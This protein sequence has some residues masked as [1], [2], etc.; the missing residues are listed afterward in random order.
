MEQHVCWGWRPAATASPS[1][2]SGREW[3][4]RCAWH[5]CF[6]GVGFVKC[7]SLRIGG[8]IGHRTLHE[9]GIGEYRTKGI[10][11][12]RSSASTLKVRAQSISDK[13]RRRKARI[14]ILAPGKK[15]RRSQFTE[16]PFGRRRAK[17]SEQLTKGRDAQQRGRDCQRH[18]PW[19]RMWTM[20]DL[21]QDIGLLDYAKPRPDSSLSHQDNDSQ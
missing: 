17:K 9:K 16:A 6:V 2:A 8:C 12:P 18:G 3:G 21:G 11:R 13:E 1:A 20:R 4:P 7:F 5:C 15:E 19:L 14:E 10:E